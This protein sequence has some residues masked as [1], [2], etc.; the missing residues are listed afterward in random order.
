MRFLF[1]FMCLKGSGIDLN[2]VTQSKPDLPIVFARR[3]LR[4]SAVK[5]SK[6][7]YCDLL[8]NFLQVRFPAL[9]VVKLVWALT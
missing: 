1:D 9:W 6:T 3:S 2:R 7:V 5:V 4:I 8:P